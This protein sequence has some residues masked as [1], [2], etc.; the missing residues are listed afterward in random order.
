MISSDP[1]VLFDLLQSDNDHHTAV[2]IAGSD[3]R[4]SYHALRDQIES[5]AA[6]LD[7]AGVERG[8]R[9][10]IALPNGLSAITCFLAASIAGTAAPLNPAYTEEEFRFYLDD[11]GARTLIVAQ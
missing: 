8:D 11:T 9:V 6:A 3:V 1:T 5:L 2:A 4:V 7:A 10:G